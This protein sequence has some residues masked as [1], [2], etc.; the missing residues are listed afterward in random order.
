MKY[1]LA[2]FDMDGTILDTLEDMTDA[3]NHTL[4]LFGMPERTIDEVRGF[5]GNGI[6][7][8]IQRA[9]PEGT[10]EAK[11][12]E[13]LQCF[14]P[15][16]ALH[17]QDKTRP[18]TGIPELLKDLRAAGVRTAVVSNKADPAVQKLSTDVFPG[19][20]DCAVGSREGFANKPAPDSVLAVL[21]QLDIPAAD[22]V[23]IGDS[24]VD[25]ATAKNAGLPCIAVSWGFRDTPFLK[26][27]G[28]T[29]IAN[30]PAEILPWI[31]S[32]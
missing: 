10:D 25:L 2:V 28:A 12:N 18:Y 13:M 7:K 11:Q 6:P 32:D 15:W 23:Y 19:L 17:C 24:D 9:V 29:L 31:L 26:A 21:R 3:T 14:L 8:L 5:V 27:H 4:A 16:Y 1:R 20:F 22:A 30:T